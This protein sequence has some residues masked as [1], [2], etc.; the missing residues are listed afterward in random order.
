MGERPVS[1]VP[2]APLPRLG[3][4]LPQPRGNPAPWKPSR[5]P[6]DSGLSCCQW[7][8]LTIDWPRAMGGISQSRGD[9]WP[10]SGTQEPAAFFLPALGK[11]PEETAVHRAFI[12][13][14][15][16][17]WSIGPDT[18]RGQAGSAPPRL[19]VPRSPFPSF[20][21]YHICF[22]GTVF[23]NKVINFASRFYLLENPG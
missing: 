4:D 5:L 20:F 1:Q 2:C 15:E 12:R 21:S 19:W 16:D 13:P 11:L 9:L 7:W 3:S 10:I 22:P 8:E 18:G 23:P 6:P 14:F 17:G